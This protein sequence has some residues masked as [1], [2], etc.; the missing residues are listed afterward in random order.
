[1]HRNQAA[2]L[3]AEPIVG[4]GD[5]LITVPERCGTITLNWHSPGEIRAA[6]DTDAAISPIVTVG[7]GER[8]PDCVSDPLTTRFVVSA[9]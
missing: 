2:G 9:P 8:F 4:S 1:M 3:G 5:Y 7:K 6:Y